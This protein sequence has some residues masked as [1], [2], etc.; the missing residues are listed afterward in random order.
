MTPPT[1]RAVRDA[2]SGDVSAIVALLDAKRAEYE[3]YSRV[4]WRRAVDAVAV[5]EPFV[6]ALVDQD[7]P[8]ALVQDGDCR[9][10]GAVIALPRADDWLVDDFAVRDPTLWDTIGAALLDE[11][12]HRVAGSTVTVVCAE[13]DRAE[14]R[15]LRTAGGILRQQWWV[16]PL[17]DVVGDDQIAD[18]AIGRV[19]NAPP[20][21][22]PGGQVAVVESWDGSA[23][24]LATIERWARNQQAVLA[25]V[26]VTAGNTDREEV[27]RTAGYDIASQW[28]VFGPL[29]PLASLTK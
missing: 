12:R 23:E 11:V 27:L 6:K 21:Y 20:V 28:Y 14:C 24:P 13:R 4:F 25:V 5:H 7:D 8:V 15:L 29:T 17:A 18:G 2:M 3:R 22:D 10:D 19:V 26:P 16:R 9:M 1:S